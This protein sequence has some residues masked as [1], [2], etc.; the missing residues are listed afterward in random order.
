MID[1]TPWSFPLYGDSPSTVELFRRNGAFPVFFL[2]FFLI[3]GIV[4]FRLNYT[5]GEGILLDREGDHWGLTDLGGW[6]GIFTVDC[7]W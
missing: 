1:F 5:K 6:G 2:S 7:Q 3:S 4:S